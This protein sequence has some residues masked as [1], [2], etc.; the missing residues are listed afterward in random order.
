MSILLWNLYLIAFWMCLEFSHSKTSL[1]VC[2]A[3]P[4]GGLSAGMAANKVAN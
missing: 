2:A 3:S 1:S 4:A